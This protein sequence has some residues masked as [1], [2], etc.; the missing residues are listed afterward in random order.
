MRGQAADMCP[1]RK[2][3]NRQGLVL[4]AVMVSL[5]LFAVLGGVLLK[6][7]L[8][9]RRQARVE[10]WRAQSDWIAE[11]AIER[12]AAQLGKSAE[13]SGES[14]QVPVDRLAEGN[15][16]LVLI[17]VD[18]SADRQNRIDVRVIADF[19]C[20]GQ[21]AARCTKTVAIEMKSN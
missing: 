11:S 19:E 1:L 20:N 9:E 12:A 10:E 7:A 17:E 4:I 5:A 18:R 2:L 13:Y 15:S 21:R 14:W 3:G 16:C 8:T 6:L